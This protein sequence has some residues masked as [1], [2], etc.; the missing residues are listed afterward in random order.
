MFFKK[1]S[2]YNNYKKY[3]IGTLFKVGLKDFLVPQGLCYVEPYTFISCYTTNKENSRV[4]M[5]DKNGVCLKEIILDNKSH[6]GGISYDKR[7]ELV[8]IC[9]SKGMVDSYRY[10]E[11]IEG[12]ISSKRSYSV[13][14]N[15]LG[16]SK[17]LEDGNMVSS[18][19]TVYLDKLYVGSFNKKTNGL[20]KVFDIIR[21]NGH[22]S[23]KYVR[24]FIVPSKIQGITFYDSG[25]STYMLLSRSYTRVKDSEILVFRY[26]KDID[27]YSTSFFSFNLPPMLEQIT[28]NNGKL[29]LLFESFA[30]KY[31]Y[32]ARIVIDDII[33]LNTNAIIEDFS[34]LII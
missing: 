33:K 28:D 8:W 19:L 7:N 31:S 4:C 12:D 34:N 6:V 23:L 26:S 13:C 16:G 14:D 3:K 9:S 32:N 29:L 25:N 30:K 11:F 21:E 27:D 18:Y 1:K 24:E 20:I 17:L 15:S 10:K 5:F 22:T 2:K